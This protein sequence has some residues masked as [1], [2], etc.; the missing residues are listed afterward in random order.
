MNRHLVSVKVRVVGGT[1]EGMQLDGLAFDEDGFE[2]LNSKTVQ[3][4]RP[5]QHDG[6]FP[7][8][9]IKDIPYLW[10]FLFHDLFGGLDGD[11]EPL[12][13]KFP[14]D[15]GLEKL[16]GHPFGKA[17]FVQFQFRPHHDHGTTGIVHPFPKEILAE[18]ALLSPQHI[19]EGL[20]G[21]FVGSHDGAPS[22][23]IVEKG[24]HRLLQH[25]L[26][27][28]DD[29]VRGIQLQES[30][31]AVVPIDDPTIEIVQIR[32]GKPSPIKRNEGTK[33]GG[34][35]RDHGQNHPLGLVPGT[36]KRIHD[37]QA[38]YNLFLLGLGIGVFEFRSQRLCQGLQ[39]QVLQEFPDRLRANP[40]A[41]VPPL[42]VIEIPIPF[43]REELPPLQRGI[44][45]IQDYVGFKIEDAL[46]L[47]DG[48]VK[49]CPQFARDAL[50]KPDM[51]HGARQLDMAEAF[52]A[53]LGL[54][55]LYS[56]LLTDNPAVFHPL[57]LSAITLV[58]LDGSEN[59]GTKEAILFRFEGPIIDRFRFLHLTVRQGLN[60]F[61]RSQSDPYGIKFRG[62]P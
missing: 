52:P 41:E 11:G 56:A 47:A 25:P 23:P 43:L 50:Q 62:F 51:G 17:T 24:V 22:F 34:Q 59:P 58:I 30:L 1:D 38:F 45:G 48:H 44:L 32:G 21:A 4:R 37:F 29:D 9:F 55:N 57:I 36:D 18:P 61:R 54:D 35:Y 14:I 27:I 53:N 60:L 10:P 19:A 40:G 13:P 26:L 28:P 12:F 8:D 7:D 31:Q 42:S 46:Q 15:E 39:V 49:Q 6:V 33:V 16:Q 20:E 3:G 2:R 5:I